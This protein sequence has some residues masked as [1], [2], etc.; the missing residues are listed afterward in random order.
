M[1]KFVFCYISL[2]FLIALAILLFKKTSVNFTIILLSVSCFYVLLSF[3]LHPTDYKYNNYLLSD[4]D[5]LILKGV[6]QHFSLIA[7][8]YLPRIF[9]QETS[10]KNHIVKIYYKG[11]SQKDKLSIMYFFCWNDETHPN[12]FMNFI[13]KLFRRLYYGSIMDIEFIQ[14]NIDLTTGKVEQILFEKPDY[15]KKFFINFIQH[16]PQKITIHKSALTSSNRL[17]FVIS[18]WTHLFN[19]VSSIDDLQSL[20]EITLPEPMILSRNIFYRYNMFRRSYGEF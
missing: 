10:D 2:I 7:K 4:S 11:I 5:I 19:F 3:L 20:I 17:P 16:L 18:S 1:I 13:Y 15:C 12:I 8:T 14:L 9:L 6:P